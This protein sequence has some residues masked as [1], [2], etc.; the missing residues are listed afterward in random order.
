[1]RATLFVYEPG[2]RS[3]WHTHDHEQV[4]FVEAGSGVVGVW[5][6]SAGRLVAQGDWVHVSPGE[7]H[8]HGA[9]P[10]CT[11]VHLAVNAEGGAQWLELVSDETYASAT[12]PHHVG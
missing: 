6:E 10:D 2:A 8:W 7:K 9:R 5:G 3:A 12:G 4:L 11:F 1:M